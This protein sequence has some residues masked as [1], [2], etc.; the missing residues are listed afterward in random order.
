MLYD[1][2]HGAIAALP[3]LIA[4]LN[5]DLQPEAA[6]QI[7]C[8]EVALTLGVAGVAAGAYDEQRRVIRYAAAHGCDV[9]LADLRIPSPDAPAP[10]APSIRPAGPGRAAVVGLWREG[11][12]V[13]AL[14]ILLPDNRDGLADAELALLRALAD[15][16]AQALVNA[17]RLS[18]ARE[19]A[20]D[21]EAI[22]TLGRALAETLDLERIF[23]LLYEVALKLLPEVAGAIFSLFDAELQ[24]ITCAFA[25]LD[26]EQLDPAELPPLPLKPLG[27]G[28]QSTVIHTRQPVILG[29]FEELQQRTALV[30]EIG[31]EGEMT[32]SSLIVPMIARERVVGVLQVQS[33]TPGCYDM[34]HATMLGLAANVAAVAIEN[35]RL[36][37]ALRSSNSELL[38]AYDSTLEGWSRALDLRDKETEGHSQRVTDLAVLLA[39][40]A[41][42][43]DEQVRYMRWG[44][45]LHD[46]G[47]MGVPDAVLLKPGK[48]D[49]EEWRLMRL[50]P[51]YAYSLLE[52]ITFLRPALDIPY[53][54]HEKWDG[55]G[56][57]RGLCGEE[58]PLA[59]RLFAV[60]DIWD[61]LRSDRPYR[62]AWD[63]G[64]T[65][66]HIRSIAGSHLDP[67]AVELFFRVIDEGATP[68][69]R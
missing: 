30:V 12:P 35:A 39:H 52:P 22:N 25:I 41:G 34:A 43:S 26:G 38:Q 63:E 16:A 32:E 57:P 20:E 47:K 48:L 55:T 11:I 58:I 44:A 40:A 6:L 4:R 8:D 33:F 42:M 66:A 9:Q 29:S 3:R 17:I 24:Q 60:I 51:A 10:P 28:T 2:T 15:L 53:C 56:Y 21:L 54:H 49:D 7:I 37:T 13:G 65:R 46:I 62:P 14:A 36:V 5:A 45:L 31:T 64:R 69:R 59:A 61:A 27:Q 50:H 18:S 1:S 23:E 68:R 19:R 67:A